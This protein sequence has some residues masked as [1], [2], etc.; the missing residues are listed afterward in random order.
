L[1]KTVWI[2]GIETLQSAAASMIGYNNGK[3][4]TAG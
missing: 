1:D 4:K 2:K 3:M